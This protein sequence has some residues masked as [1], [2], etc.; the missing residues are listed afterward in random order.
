MYT[1]PSMSNPEIAGR[2]PRKNQPVTQKR[3]EFLGLST[4]VAVGGGITLLGGGAIAAKIILGELPF[5]SNEIVTPPHESASLI[6]NTGSK[7]LKWDIENQTDLRIGFNPSA[8]E[9][10]YRFIRDLAIKYYSIA[11]EDINKINLILHENL[12][13]GVLMWAFT[14]GMQEFE[15]ALGDLI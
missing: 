10:R 14:M 3:R 1:S 5:F 7:D 9:S 15:L 6:I 8:I 12:D 2:R 4:R 13:K 11:F